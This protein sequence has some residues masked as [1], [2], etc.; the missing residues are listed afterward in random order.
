MQY[1]LELS[2]VVSRIASTCD[3]TLLSGGIDTTFVVLSHPEKSR[4][5]AITVDLGGSDAYYA[6][7]VASRLGLKHVMKR[8]SL[9]SL[10]DA[11][12]RI[13]EMLRII[14]PIEVAADAVH[15]TSLE[16]A[17]SE[18][19]RC[20][21]TGDGG[22]ELFLGYDF[23]LGLPE[24]KLREWLDRV[25]MDAWLPTV[26]IGRKLGLDVVAPLYGNEAKEL[27]RLLPIECLVDRDR[28]HGKLVLRILIANAGLEEVAWRRKEPVT[29]GSGSLSLLKKL[30]ESSSIPGETVRK[31]L[32]FKP[33]STTHLYLAWRLI[34]RASPPPPCPEDYKRCPICNRCLERGFCK[35]CGAYL[36]EKGITSHYTG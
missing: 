17:R 2:R 4:L 27:V 29:S 13:V 25:M 35:F 7:L 5:K 9:E 15:L 30:A 24:D 28:G 1:A 6:R 31:T 10:R 21:L 14:D 33:P 12:D 23:L 11:I 34:S 19:C 22:D 3:C 36:D 18:G 8:P 26:W 16:T 32:G 20:V